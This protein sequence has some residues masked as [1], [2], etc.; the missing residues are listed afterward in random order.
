MDG[1]GTYFIVH[2]YR[3]NGAKFTYQLPIP[4]ARWIVVLHGLKWYT[5]ED[6]AR[7]F[8]SNWDE[9]DKFLL[10]KFEWATDPKTGMVRSWRR[11]DVVIQRVN[12]AYA[13]GMKNRAGRQAEAQ[14]E[15]DQIPIL[16]DPDSGEEYVEEPRY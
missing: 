16:V 8:L 4:Q 7:L 14:R 10:E 3:S 13:T 15:P 1:C 5:T 2:A 11:D 9:D 6:E 12:A